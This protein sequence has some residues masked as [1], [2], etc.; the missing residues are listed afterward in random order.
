MAIFFIFT[1]AVLNLGVGFAVAVVIKRRSMSGV[2]AEDVDYAETDPV[3][4]EQSVLEVDETA[5]EAIEAVEELLSQVG[6][7]PIGAGASDTDEGDESVGDDDQAADSPP[8]GEDASES[9][10]A[11]AGSTQDDLDQESRLPSEETSE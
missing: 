8:A 1:I 2:T 9:P 10:T 4:E 7:Q 11:D 6:L 3:M 5:E